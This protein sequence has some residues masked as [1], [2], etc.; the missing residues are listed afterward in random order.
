LFK[1]ARKLATVRVGLSV[2]DSITIKAVPCGPIASYTT[3]AKPLSSFEEAR[4]MAASILSFGICA[5][6]A[7]CMALRKL[8]LVSGL[9]PPSLTAIAISLPAL[10]NAFAILSQ[11]ANF[12]AL[13]YS[14][15]RPIIVDL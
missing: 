12:D 6:F 8:G 1:I 7:F 4:F 3:I 14:N 2:A 15:A 11:R 13:R 9:G 5:F 10:V